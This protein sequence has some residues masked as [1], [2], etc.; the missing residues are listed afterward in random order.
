[1]I[2]RAL[3]LQVGRPEV[4]RVIC[5]EIGVNEVDAHDFML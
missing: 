4:K 2:H 1:M 5:G 3:L